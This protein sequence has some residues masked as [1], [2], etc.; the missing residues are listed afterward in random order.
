MRTILL[1][2]LGVLPVTAACAAADDA[3]DGDVVP[4]VSGSYLGEY[5]VPTTPE[6]AA[7]AT[8]RVDHVDWTVVGGV[9]TLHY[10][11]PEG[12]VGGLLDITL[13]GPVDDG[14]THVTVTGAQGVGECTAVGTVI[15]C[16]EDF[17]DLGPL[18][19]SMAVVEQ[20]AAVEYAGPAA[21]RMEVAAW[22]GSDPIGIVTFDITVPGIDDH[23]EDD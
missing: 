5:T 11:L 23:G 4:T 14:A 15:T 22:F 2:L 7:A 19:I 16:H 3:G 21:D 10:E 20:L 18:P 8:Y 12:L 1:A 6:L 9:V 17:A 13:T